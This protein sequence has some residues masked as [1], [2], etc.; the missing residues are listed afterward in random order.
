VAFAQFN[1]NEFY[2]LKYIYFGL[3]SFDQPENRECNGGTPGFIPDEYLQRNVS[4][5]KFDVY[6]LGMTFLDLE[7]NERG[8]EGFSCV[9]RVLH[10]R[11][12]AGGYEL[13]QEDLQKLNQLELVKRMKQIMI[14]ENY[15]LLFLDML[16]EIFSSIKQKVN[17]NKKTLN[18]SLINCLDY[19]E[20]SVHNFC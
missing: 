17:L 20:Q 5:E 6:S 8:Y 3:I 2:Q 18:Y 4:N 11:K 12:K 19:F 7:L 13:N 1:H 15:R 14:D 10:R 16:E 9:D